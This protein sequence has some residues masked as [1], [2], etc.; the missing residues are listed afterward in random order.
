MITASPYLAAPT[1][2][3]RT[4]QRI[5]SA[6]S[7]YVERRIAARAERRELAAD[8]LREQRARRQD[9]R[10]LDIALLAIGSRPR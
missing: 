3:E 6:L 9:P 4:L 5:A 2:L 8:L 7:R 1:P 10:A